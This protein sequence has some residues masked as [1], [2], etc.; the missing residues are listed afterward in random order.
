MFSLKDQQGANK[1]TVKLPNMKLK[2]EVVMV[3]YNETTI[4]HLNNILMRKLMR[5]RTMNQINQKSRT[6][7]LSMNL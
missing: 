5:A 4:R 2:A 3:F 7:L 6:V 1:D